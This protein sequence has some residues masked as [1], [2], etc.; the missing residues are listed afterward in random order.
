MFVAVCFCCCCGLFADD[1]Q[2]EWY[3]TL[4][5]NWLRDHT[6]ILEKKVQP[7]LEERGIA[8]GISAKVRWGREGRG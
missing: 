5:S 2:P 3:L 6:P 8:S 7:I 4:V 1:V